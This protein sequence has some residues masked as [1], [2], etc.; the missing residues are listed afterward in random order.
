MEGRLTA[1]ESTSCRV[2][3]GHRLPWQPW[4]LP[5]DHRLRDAKSSRRNGFEGQTAAAGRVEGHTER[6]AEFVAFG[7]LSL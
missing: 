7:S 4:Q 5:C 6:R 3:V 1:G 2:G